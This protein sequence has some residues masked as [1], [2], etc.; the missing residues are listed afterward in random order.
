MAP[1][2]S[3]LGNRARLCLLKKI[4]FY[5]IIKELEKP[6]QFLT[7]RALILS[8]FKTYIEAIEIERV[9]YWHKYRYIDQ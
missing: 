4:K 8:D 9:W 2:H 5:E 3:S 1:L 7:R 6:K